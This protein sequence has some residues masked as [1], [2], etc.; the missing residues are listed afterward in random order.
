MPYHTGFTCNGFSAYLK[1][2][3]CR[4]CEQSVANINPSINRAL[5]VCDSAECKDKQSKSCGK[6]LKCGHACCGIVG[7]QECLP[8]LNED[9]ED[10]KSSGLNQH[11]NEYCTICYTDALSS[12]P[13][14]RLS[15]KH[16]F[17]QDCILTILKNGHPGKR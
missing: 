8:C 6:V 10:F 9:C 4:F 16:V 13:C 2:A 15:C 7:E 1:S 3:K 12:A 5:V 14:I 11:S 17:H